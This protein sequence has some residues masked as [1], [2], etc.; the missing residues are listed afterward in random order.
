MNQDEMFAFMTN[1]AAGVP[2]Q[3]FGDNGHRVTCSVWEQNNFAFHA[4]PL[5]FHLLEVCNS[6]HHY[7]IVGAEQ[8]SSVKD[9]KT[10]AG[11][12]NYFCP[13]QSI[14]FEAEGQ[15]KFYQLWLDRAVFDDVAA[16][17]VKGGSNNITPLAFAGVFDPLISRAAATILNESVAPSAASQLMIDAAAQQ[18]A[19]LV[20]RRNISRPISVSQTRPLSQ[21]ET[22]R[23]IDFLEDNIDRNDGL[24]A[25]AASIDMSPFHFGRAFKAA[26]GQAPHQFLIERRIARVRDQLTSS[27]QTLA[28]IAYACGFSSQAHMTTTFS[29]HVGVTP[30]K[31]RK[32]ARS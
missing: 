24:Q 11:A 18:I 31:Y 1:E 32:L 12:V 28:D 15:A 22:N 10:R 21:A 2:T 17:I 9:Y 8:E 20:L 26:T 23:V 27:T 5:D 4:S 3:Q 25:V 13:D 29:K 19:I 6:G 14:Y 30:G 16:N 7:G